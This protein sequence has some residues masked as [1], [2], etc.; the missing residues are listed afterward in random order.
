MAAINHVHIAAPPSAVFATL[1]T[2]DRYADWVVGASDIRD[3]DAG[4]PAPGTRFHHTQGIPHVGLKDTT[5]VLESEAPR[6]L[7]LEV[8]ARPLI[9]ARVTLD[10]LGDAN[11]TRLTMTESPTGGWL[12]RV[13]GRLLD[14]LIQLRNAEALRRL[15]RLCEG[16]SALARAS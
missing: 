3:A 13:D 15:R 16:R 12:A 7:V 2:T 14:R 11:G 6:R 5:E 9:V 4:W 10:L 1:A 8:R